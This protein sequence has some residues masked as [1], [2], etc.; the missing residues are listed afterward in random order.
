LTCGAA[1]IRIGMDGVCITFAGAKGMCAVGLSIGR[2]GAGRSNADGAAPGVA[3][4]GN[5]AKYDGVEM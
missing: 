2:V 4:P 1:G 5:G 3:G